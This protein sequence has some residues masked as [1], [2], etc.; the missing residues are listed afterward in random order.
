VTELPQGWV[1]V[2]VGDVAASLVDG[3][4][5]SNLKT[6]HYTAEGVRVIRLQNIGDG[7][8][9]DTDKAFIAEDRY[10]LLRR[11]DAQP[12]DVLIAAMGDVLPRVCMVPPQ[13]GVTIVKADCFRLRHNGLVD[14]KYLAFA[15]QSPQVRA[16]AAPQIAG[17]GRP[18]L[19]LRKVRNLPLALAPLAEQ[20]RIVAAIE[21][22]FLRIDASVSSLE[23]A[24]RRLDKMRDAIRFA[25]TQGRLVPQDSGDEPAAS[26]IARVNPTGRF[27]GTKPLPSDLGPIPPGWSWALMGALAQRVTVGHVGPMKDEYV[28]DGVPFLRSQNVRDDR[29]DPEGLRYISPAFHARLSKS[30]LA[31]GDVVI[32]RSGNVGTA[33]V[34]PESVGE[35][36]CAD[37]VIV[38]RPEAVDPYYATLY[39]NSLARS[40]VR[41]GRVGVALTHFNTQSVAELPVPVPPLNEQKRIVAEA[42]RLMSM[43]DA[44]EVNINGGLKKARALRSS[45]LTAA[46]S[47]RMTFQDP[48]EE[49]ASALLERITA[50]QAAP[51]GRRSTARVPRSAVV[52]KR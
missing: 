7:R 25:A 5:G 30:R 31:P 51:D 17:V 38:Q 29:F 52:P 24:R 34:V 43:V 47:G 22:A 19:N 49:P 28:P 9:D 42:Q 12:G 44:L 6:E 27:R 11:H 1:E 20:K 16:A 14:G 4:F 15:L 48:D 36:N 32:V 13:L 50:Q 2:R 21:E 18:R 3:P 40:R 41:A 39:M 8:F 46:F 37:L 26:F 35:A 33:C 10:Q 45:V 23:V